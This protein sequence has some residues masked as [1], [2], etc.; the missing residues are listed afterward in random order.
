MAF[1]NSDAGSDTKSP[2]AAA[3]RRGL[4]GFTM[5][6][7]GGDGARRG[8]PALSDASS[9]AL[10]NGRRRAGNGFGSMALSDADADSDQVQLRA[11]LLH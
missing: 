1:S 3:P 11:R 4:F 7:S 9:D 10:S 6:P 2:V 5:A 8:A